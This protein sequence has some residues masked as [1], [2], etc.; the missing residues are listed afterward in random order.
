MEI[1]ES[2]IT[3]YGYTSPHGT[4]H[5][6]ENQWRLKEVSWGISL[7]RKIRRSTHGEINNVAWHVTRYVR[8]LSFQY[9]SHQRL[10]ASVLRL[11]GLHELPENSVAVAGPATAKMFTHSIR[12]AK[13]DPLRL[14][15]FCSGCWIAT[16]ITRRTA[17]RIARISRRCT[18][19]LS[20]HRK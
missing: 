5:M 8:R 18:Q 3:K 2:S 4:A 14:P 9:W 7:A 12:K 16:G 15:S 13:P 20:F 19:L 17:P 1:L 11:Q 6:T 10:K